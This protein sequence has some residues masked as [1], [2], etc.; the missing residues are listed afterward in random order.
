MVTTT[1]AAQRGKR[2][3]RKVGL[4][5]VNPFERGIERR[6]HGKGFTYVSPSGKTV[7]SASTRKRIE[8]LVIP[9]AWEDVWICPKSRGHIQAV[10]RDAA[11]RKQYIYHPRWVTVSSATKYDRMHLMAKLLPRIRRRV[12][13]DL[14][15]RKLTR[16]RVLAAVVRLLDKAHIRIGNERYAEERG[17][18]GATTLTAEHVEV[19]RFTI[20][21]DF[22]GKSGRHQEIEISDP[23]VA[24]VIRQC[25][26]IN[27]QY[28][29]C[30]GGDDGET[31]RIDSTDVNDYLGEIAGES[32]TAKDFRTW[33]GSVIALS[34]LA[35]LDDSLSKTQRKRAIVAAVGIAADALGNTKTLCRKSYIHPGLLAAAETGEL[36]KLVAK[37]RQS[38]HSHHELTNDQALLAKILPRLEFS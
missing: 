13:K 29:F 7:K 28:L 1:T 10:G 32:I 20:S 22:P 36:A 5:Y 6:R 17:S 33:W 38:N 8:S 23:T 3:A 18:R 31:C 25:E 21:L 2:R 9:P 16:Q 30:Y 19:E 24:K 35:D 27:G 11:G 37:A 34:E 4:L 26:E 14:K 15:G 12:R